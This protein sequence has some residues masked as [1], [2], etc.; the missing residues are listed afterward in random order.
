MLVSN[1]FANPEHFAIHVDL[2]FKNAQKFNPIESPIHRAACHLAKVFSERYNQLF[3]PGKELNITCLTTQWLRMSQSRR[4]IIWKRLKNLRLQFASSTNLLRVISFVNAYKLFLDLK[5][6]IE[7]IKDSRKKVQPRRIR[8]IRPNGPLSYAEKA[9]LC[10]VI[11]EL[12][13]QEL[14][15]FLALVQEPG[16]VSNFYL[17]RDRNIPQEGVVEI[18]IESLDDATLLRAQQ[19]LATCPTIKSLYPNFLNRNRSLSISGEG[20]AA[21]AA[22]KFVPTGFFFW[23]LD[24]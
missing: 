1:A 13:E 11:P 14:R 9:E 21:K 18:D 5:D 7:A 2:V 22:E 15:G 12:Q 17:K 19:Y 16:E 4:T 8:L 6:S 3:E 24:Y 20:S 23:N 10:K